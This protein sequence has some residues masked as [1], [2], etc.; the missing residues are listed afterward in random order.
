[1]WNPTGCQPRAR[2]A[3]A[4]RR[5]SRQRLLA[6]VFALGVGASLAQTGSGSDGARR[7]SDDLGIVVNQTFTS[8]G[9]E[10][11]RRFTDFWREKPDFE[12]LT[13]VILERPSLRYGNR[14]T[15]SAGQT[16]VYT[17][18]LPAKTEAIRALSADA[19]ERAYAN[20]IA[21]G[22]RLNGALDPDIGPDEI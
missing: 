12:S 17:G 7:P 5:S 2:H 11:Y 15:V 16:V 13:L 20:I 9:Q 10:F 18:N 3:N 14:V 1:M 8:A 22:L 21:S 4:L 19:V 6:A